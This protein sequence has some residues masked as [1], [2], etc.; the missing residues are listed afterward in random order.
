[1]NRKPAKCFQDL[2]VWQKSHQ[3]VL[4]T[5]GF[6]SDFPKTEMYGLTSQLRRA[7]ISIPTNIAEGFKKEQSLIKPGL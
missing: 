4:S 6:S 2:I 5:Y 7:A 1:M 3:F